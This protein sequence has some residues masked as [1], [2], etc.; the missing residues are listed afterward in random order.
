MD[1]KGEMKY[2]DGTKYVGDFKNEKRNGFGVTF[3]L[4]GTK[5]SGEWEND[6]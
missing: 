6:Q 1:G 3:N 2:S 5:H 4:D